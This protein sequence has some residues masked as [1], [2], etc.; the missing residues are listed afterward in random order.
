MAEAT[1]VKQ[2][3]PPYTSFHSLRSMI[4]WLKEMDPLPARIDRSLW[5]SKYSGSA[6]PPLMATAR[7]LGLLDGEQ[8]TQALTELIQADD[9]ERRNKFEELI[10]RGYGDDFVDGVR[11]MTPKMLDDHLRAMGTTDSTHR[12]AVSFL[13]NA[14]K[15]HRRHRSQLHRQE[16]AKHS[17]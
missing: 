12:K 17:P 16:S 7:F 5:S 11:E 1:G 2:Q 9:E 15:G 10:R 6:G 13:I 4:E 14:L 8:P 3:I